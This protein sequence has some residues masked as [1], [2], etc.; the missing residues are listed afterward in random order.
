MN[1]INLHAI[2]YYNI[3]PFKDQTRSLF[4]AKG[5]YLIKAPIGSGKSFLFFDGPLYGLYK[6]SNRRMVNSLSDTANIK[7][8]FEIAGQHY[9]LVRQLKKGKSKDSCKSKLFNINQIP[10]LPQSSH[11][12][13]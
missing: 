11:I 7:L 13:E 3:G 1:S 5:K 9:F 6:Y 8:W 2:S 12:Q 10:P 4:F